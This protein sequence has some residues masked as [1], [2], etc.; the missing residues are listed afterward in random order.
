MF[1]RPWL[2]SPGASLWVTGTTR[3]G[4]V[5]VEKCSPGMLSAVLVARK[6]LIAKQV[7]I[8][9]DTKSSIELSAVAGVYAE[10]EYGC[11]CFRRI[12]CVLYV[13]KTLHMSFKSLCLAQSC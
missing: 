2:N 5:S 11:I 10:A 3:L 9:G 6:D 4:R 13:F 1:R 12:S 7:M 8:S